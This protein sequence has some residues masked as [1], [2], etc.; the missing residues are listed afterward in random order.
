ML[1][2]HILSYVSHRKFG[3]HGRVN[4]DFYH[5]ISVGIRPVGPGMRYVIMLI[6]VYKI[7]NKTGGKQK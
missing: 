5:D 7:Y 2:M 6:L 3:E 1:S 4:R